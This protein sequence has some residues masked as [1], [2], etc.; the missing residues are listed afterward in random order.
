MCC[1]N[2]LLSTCAAC[3]CVS[4]NKPITVTTLPGA[5][6]SAHVVGAHSKPIIS[7]LSAGQNNPLTLPL[8]FPFHLAPV[9][10]TGLG[11]QYQQCEFDVELMHQ[12]EDQ[13]EKKHVQSLQGDM[14]LT[15]VFYL[16]QVALLPC[17][18]LALR[19]WKL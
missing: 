11:H 16:C 19:I 5:A 4:V 8:P 13:K 10:I 15:S 18:I 7:V 17:I 1:V 14:F 3:W 9:Y 12:T 2:S 6:G